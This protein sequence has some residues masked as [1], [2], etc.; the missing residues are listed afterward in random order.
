[1]NVVSRKLYQGINPLL[2]ELHSLRFNLR[3]KWWGT[4][5]QW[6]DMG[7]TV[8][9]RPDDVEPGHWGASIVLVEAVHEDGRP[10][11]GEEEEDQFFMM[12]YFTVFSADQVEG[13]AAEKFQVMDEPA[14]RHVLPDYAPAEELIAATGADIRFGGDRAYYCRP[15]PE[16]SWPNH[17]AATTSASAQASVQSAG[18][19]LRDGNPRIVPIGAR[20]ERAGSTTSKASDGR[21]C[22]RNR[23]QL[24]LH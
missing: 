19:I 3:S 22:R 15:V 5:H 8:K 2:F 9:K 4:F 21:T 24:P 7:C 6:S 14:H 12:R 20:C 1:M 16:G 17:R 23:R 10:R 13:K 11:N 18:G